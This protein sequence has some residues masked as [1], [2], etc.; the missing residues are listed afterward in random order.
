MMMAASDKRHQLIV[1]GNFQTQILIFV[2]SWD[3]SR[4]YVIVKD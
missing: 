4:N 1:F 3:D 2:P